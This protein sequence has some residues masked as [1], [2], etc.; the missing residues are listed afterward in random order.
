MKWITA[1]I[2]VLLLLLLGCSQ[3]NPFKADTEV[4]WE[5]GNE[6]PHI[7]MVGTESGGFGSSQFNDL[8]PDRNGIQDAVMLS[9]DKDINPLTIIAASFKM[10]E[11]DPGTGPVQFESISYYPEART[12][13]LVGTFTDNTAYLLTVTAGGVQDISGNQLDPNHN[14]LYD[15]SPWDD[16]RATFFA[17]SAAMCD[18]TSPSISNY[19]PRT[20]DISTLLPIPRVF[21]N[22]G[23][24]D[25]SLLNLDNFTLVRTS[26]SAS[27]VLQL[28][29][30]TPN[31][32][33]ATPVSDLSYGTR[34]TVRLSAQVADSSGNYLD[35]NGD[36]YIWPNEPDLVWD[37]RIIDDTT[38]HTEPPAVD[39][40]TLMSGNTLV[41]I[42][43]DKSLS[44]DDV[45][46]DAATFIA[47]NIQ[48]IDSNGSIPI[49]FETAA[50]P[51]AVNCLLQRSTEGTATLH[52]SCEVADEY[53]NLL[54][55]NNDGLGGTPGEDDWSGTL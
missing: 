31:D 27:V 32:I 52:I 10:V 22:D 54:D 53:G 14:A 46:M 25:V 43:F 36:G 2:S 19:Y 40:A 45:V 39:Q 49:V 30:A 51:G 8:D 42:E 9:F 26:D 18:I 33:F 55:G 7:D 44:G 13:V 41:R 38:T 47:A 11:T 16:R 15:G 48:V 35:T 5:G 29:N 12:A 21:F 6:H 34:Y 4:Q 28:V 20:G 3:D 23:P 17:G 37:F 24:M 1:G 50:D